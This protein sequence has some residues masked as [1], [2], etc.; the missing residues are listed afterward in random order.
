MFNGSSHQVLDVAVQFVRRSE[1]FF[2]V[3]PAQSY[4][5]LIAT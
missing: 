1:E 4:D 2:M 5:W 3:P